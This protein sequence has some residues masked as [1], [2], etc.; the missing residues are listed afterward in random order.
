MFIQ[1][2]EIITGGLGTGSKREIVLNLNKV[3]S[4]REVSKSGGG[5]I[6]ETRRG[7]VQVTTPDREVLSMMNIITAISEDE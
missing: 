5:T 4:F 7:D 1:F 2:T 3:I 6:F